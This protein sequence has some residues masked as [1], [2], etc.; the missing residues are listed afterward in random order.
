MLTRRAALFAMAA[1][2][3]NTAVAKQVMG[4]PTRAAPSGLSS[5][6]LR[7][8]PPSSSCGWSRNGCPRR[9]ASL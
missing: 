5:P 1:T 8:A 7:A 3:F 2:T 9:W 4:N 6:K